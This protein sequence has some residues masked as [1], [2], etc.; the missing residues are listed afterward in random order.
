M[1]MISVYYTKI[2]TILSII[3]ASYTISLDLI[4]DMQNK[5]DIVRCFGNMVVYLTVSLHCPDILSPPISSLAY[6]T[7]IGLASNDDVS[8]GVGLDI[9]PPYWD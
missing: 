4:R 9:S 7:A 1:T 2:Y 3:L 8:Y 6:P 5:L